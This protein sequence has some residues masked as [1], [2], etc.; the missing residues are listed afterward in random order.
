MSC[1]RPSGRDGASRSCRASGQAMSR[2]APEARTG[3]RRRRR[4]GTRAVRMG[5][6]TRVA[7]GRGDVLCRVTCIL[8]AWR[9][10]LKVW[11]EAGEALSPSAVP[12]LFLSWLTT[13]RNVFPLLG[14]GWDPK[15]Q[16]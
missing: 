12:V 13:H 4:N 16:T 5:V 14:L 10:G 7:T 11:V 15:E 6:A 3:E 9:A 2:A 8:S 1:L